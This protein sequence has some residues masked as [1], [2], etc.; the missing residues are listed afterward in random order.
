MPL[1]ADL[2]ALGGAVISLQPVGI[3]ELLIRLGE[4]ALGAE[5]KPLQPPP[6]GDGRL[7]VNNGV[8]KPVEPELALYKPQVSSASRQPP[9]LA[10][11]RLTS[12]VREVGRM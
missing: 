10:K 6:I 5:L 4:E 2:A 9:T 12:P 11:A 3:S 8:G 7:G 1:G